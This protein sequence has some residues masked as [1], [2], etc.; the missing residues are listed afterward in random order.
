LLGST[1]RRS[2]ANREED[3]IET[4]NA[5]TVLSGTL[6]IFVAFDWGEEVDLEKARR[7]VPAEAQGLARRPRTP[8]SIAYRPPPL[9]YPLGAVPLSL[10]EIGVLRADAEASLFDFGG[11]STALHVPFH[12]TLPQLTR[13]AGWL[14]EPAEVIQASRIALNSLH[15][16][17]RPAIHKPIWR[18]DLSEEYLVFELP[19]GPALEPTS[20]LGEHP[21]WLAGL[22]LL[23]DEPL[24]AEE[25]EDAVRLHISY[26]PE[27]L[28]LA[29]WGAAV[30]I[31]R[32]C[33]ETLRVIEFCN[34]QLLEFR[35]ID[36]LLDDILAVAHRQIEPTE[37][38]WL[39]VWRA[40]SRPMRQ[41]GELKVDAN[42]VFER[43]GNVLKLVGDQYLA[44]V[45]RQLA[46]RFHLEA[47]EESIRR[48]LEVI[49]GLYKVLS[50]QANTG[51]GELLELTVVI[52]ILV[53]IVVALTRH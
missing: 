48:K 2:V 42:E 23:D 40:Y 5:D 8:P 53:E 15:T 4:L 7:L 25:V 19:P 11:I 43:T 6:H 14:A 50:D 38:S 16:Q 45:Y 52:L 13:L 10:P 47:W 32:N 22:L 31:D 30:L 18:E 39:P 28:L 35:Y 33:D 36:N 9:R 51:R 1:L 24:S 37:R 27:D 26:T 44:R 20:L 21:N 17:L 29:D 46:A 41:L 34:L 12:L 49:E 3:A